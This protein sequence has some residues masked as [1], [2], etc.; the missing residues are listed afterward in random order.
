M[1]EESEEEERRPRPVIK[2]N[3]T[4]KLS[5]RSTS[6]SR[7]EASAE[8]KRA[9]VPLDAADPESL[10]CVRFGAGYFARHV[11]QL[12]EVMPF[13]VIM[14]ESTGRVRRALKA[15]PPVRP[16]SGSYSMESSA[17]PQTPVTQ[18][19]DMSATTAD[20][21]NASD[22][23]HEKGSATP[24]TVTSPITLKSPSVDHLPSAIG[25][26]RDLKGVFTRRFRW[27]TVDVLEPEH[28][29]FAA[30]RTAILTTHFKVRFCVY[31]F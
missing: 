25:P 22:D 8:D 14:P 16:V 10:A 17:Y 13:A 26:P 7:L 20:S 6:R 2:L 23:G 5:T 27:G 31:W 1:E 19:G 11:R 12:S 21:G 24:T 29:D 28:C 3:P 9:P 30:L 4:R 18:N 15:P